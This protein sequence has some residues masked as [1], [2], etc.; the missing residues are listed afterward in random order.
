MTGPWCTGTLWRKREGW[1][2]GDQVASVSPVGQ[3]EPTGLGYK[4]PDW[5]AQNTLTSFLGKFVES[6]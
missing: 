3:D 5:E 1:P 6:P 2:G 4:V